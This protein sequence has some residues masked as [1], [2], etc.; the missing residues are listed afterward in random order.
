MTKVL[1][2]RCRRSSG[3]RAR[4]CR[5]RTPRSGWRPGG[6]GQALDALVRCARSLP[7]YFGT[8][9]RV[10]VGSGRR[11]AG[12]T[13]GRRTGGCRTRRAPRDRGPPAKL[14]RVTPRAELP[15]RVHGV[16]RCPLTERGCTR[17]GQ[18]VSAPAVKAHPKDAAAVAIDDHA[19][20]APPSSPHHYGLGR[21][22]PRAR[23]GEALSR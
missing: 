16:L 6:D 3:R 10:Q 11:M 13:T 23:S 20:V 4:G 12:F 22:L 19:E 17:F 5:S 18:S 15:L 2:G 7:R 9:S 1:T 14:T 8:P 21:D